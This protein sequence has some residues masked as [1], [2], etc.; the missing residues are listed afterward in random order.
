MLVRCPQCKVEIRL[1]D[2][3]P[4]A[5]VVKY[6]CPDCEQ[7]V[8]ID[9]EL[10]EVR[11]SSSSGSFRAVERRKTVLIADDSTWV[12]ERVRGQLVDAGY[13][14][15]VAE[16]GATALQRIRDEHPDLVVLDLLMP[17]V[18][19][20]DVLRT[21]RSEER[22]KNTAVVAMSSVYSDRILDFLQELGAAGFVDKRQSLDSLAFRVKRI[23]EPGVRD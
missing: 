11:S 19:G 23:I 15:I 1:V 22:I 16:D 3:R 17:R 4:D 10:D 8:R 13:N 7:I 5:R 12:L 9:L 2:Y 6:F 14:V 20:F 18:T 21:L